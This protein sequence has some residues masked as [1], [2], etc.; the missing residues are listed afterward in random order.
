MT[1]WSGSS[2]PRVAVG[3][4]VAEA[5]RGLD[6]V[7][8]DMDRRVLAR[9]RRLTVDQAVGLVL[10]SAPDMVCIDSPSGWALRGSSR[11]A[12]RELARMGISAYACPTDP[13]DH[14]FYR[15]MRVGFSIYR[16]LAP[17]FPLF[18]EG[19]A[20]GT[21]AE[22]F[23]AA[24]AALLA[25]RNKRPS[26]SKV[27]F[28]RAVLGAQGV[29]ESA[30]ATLDQVDAALA[31]LTGALALERRTTAVGDPEEGVILLPL[32]GPTPL[33]RGRGGTG[34]QRRATP[35]GS[36]STANGRRRR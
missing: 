16:G 4:D 26:E 10:E 12:E 14:P 21:A 6:V 33:P 19:D 24:T 7:A 31:A 32:A 11:A 29:D 1:E 27:A 13:G 17:A 36:R 2:S 18:R 30:L 35:Q 25:G 8:L 15:W 22:V 3:I 23:P 28:R 34:P 20:A 5:R 9:H